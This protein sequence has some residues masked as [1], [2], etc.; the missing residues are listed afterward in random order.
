LAARVPK[1][2]LTG[3]LAVDT[4]RSIERDAFVRIVD[5]LTKYPQYIMHLHGIML[6]Q[7]LTTDSP[8]QVAP[9]GKLDWSGNYS[10]LGKIPKTWVAQYLMHRATHLGVQLTQQQI[11]AMEEDSVDNLRMLFSFETQTTPAMAFPSACHDKYIATKTFSERAAQVG[12]RLS[13]FLVSGGIKSS[14]AL[15]FSHGGCYSLEFDAG[16]CTHVLHITGAKVEAPAHVFIT[17]SFSLVDNHS[18]QLARVE[19]SPS[20]YYLMDFFK[21]AEFLQRV[22]KDKK[23]ETLKKLAKAIADKHAEGI[24]TKNKETVQ[25]NR[26][27]LKETHQKRATANLEKARSKLME[28]KADRT[29][30]RT[31][32]LG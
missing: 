22:I 27:V 31:I 4:R 32:K 15:D 8:S 25:E 18:D 10:C 30:R 12:D 9:L 11:N 7:D 5:K 19:L 3:D 26:D 1:V 16:R 28:K 24:V 21:G 29:A 20:K 6:S 23:G 17:S 2:R 13:S 14:G